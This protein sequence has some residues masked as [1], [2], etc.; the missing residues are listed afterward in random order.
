M[1]TTDVQHCTSSVVQLRYGVPHGS[2]L[3]LFLFPINMLPLVQFILVH[4]VNCHF[5]ADDTQLYVPIK[6][7]DPISFKILT[8]CLSD[9]KS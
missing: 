2:T 5:Y 9:N 4:N 7:T 8:A 3:G 1:S 6:A